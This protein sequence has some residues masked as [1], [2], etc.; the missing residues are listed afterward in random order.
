[1]TVAVFTFV[2]L[3][4]NVLKEIIGLLVAGQVSLGLM[5]KAIG[6]LI[7]YVMSYVLPFAMLTAVTL[8]FGR[9]SAEHELT[10][11]RASGMSLISLVVPI[12]L[13]S[14]LLCGMCGV[15]N[16][17]VAPQCR[18]VYKNLIFQ[19]GSRSI[20][21]LITEDRFIDEIPGIVLYIRKKRGDEMEDVR[22]YTVEK[23]QITKRISARRGTIFYDPAAQ[24]IRFKL[25]E[26]ITEVRKD[27]AEEENFIGPPLPEKP[28]EWQPASAGV[29]DMEPIELTA[30]LKNERKP[31]I[32]EMNLRQLNEERQELEALGISAMPVI[33][34]THRRFSFSFAC[35]AFT[36][37][38][39][40]LAIQAHR[41]ETS[42]GVAISLGLVLTYYAFILLGEA[43]GT[44]ERLHPHLILW[45]P[46]FLFEG[47]GAVLLVR[48]SHG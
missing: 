37:I 36:L 34:E 8:V 20:S 27:P 38:G 5:L 28:A 10:A 21:N 48:A 19:L 42:I 15:F 9:F 32:S 18:S 4:G 40:P 41:R 6:L 12:L 26:V 17:W 47:L 29:Y 39:I 35:F 24:T 3:L 44:K 31:K 7:P 16:L 45:V 30:L 14:I 43:L 46:N 22:L 25:F 13:L 1:M 11:V 2:L 23:N 33:V